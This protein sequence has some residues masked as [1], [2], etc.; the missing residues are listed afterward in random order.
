MKFSKLIE[1]IWF[2]I[3]GWHNFLW[4]IALASTHLYLALSFLVSHM[5]NNEQIWM[6]F[7]KLFDI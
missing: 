1:K 6:K 2:W 4:V 5:K 7:P 3:L